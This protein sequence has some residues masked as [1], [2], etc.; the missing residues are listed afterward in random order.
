VS[1]AIVKNLSDFFKLLVQSFNLSNTFPALVLVILTRL[2]V[3]PSLAE[4]TALQP[5]ASWDGVSS[6][7]TIA[8]LVMLLAYVLDAANRPIIRLF[9][10]Y[11]FRDQWPFNRWRRRNQKHVRETW[12]SIRDLERRIDRLIEQGKREHREGPLREAKELLRRKAALI[13]E[14]A[15]KYP[16]DPEY[17]L[18]SPFGN[19]IAA[20]ERYPKKVLDMD[21]KALWPFLLPTLT[22]SDYAQVIAREKGVRDFCVNLTLV[23]GAFGCMLNWRL[24]S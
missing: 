18:C 5:P 19:V 17:V 10:G 1:S 3:W 6:A 21:A 16:D 24:F 15:D 11:W 22:E 20:A 13:R 23:V 9:E 2:F 7:G 14:V 12:G 8:L 4:R